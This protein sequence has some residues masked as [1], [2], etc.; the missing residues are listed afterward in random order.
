MVGT[1]PLLYFKSIEKLFFSMPEGVEKYKNNQ[2]NYVVLK[3]VESI[4]G[5]KRKTLLI[6]FR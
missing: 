5:M 2:Y 3:F 4:G 1:A 6:S